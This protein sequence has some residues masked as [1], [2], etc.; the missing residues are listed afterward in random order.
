IVL[1]PIVGLLMGDLQTG[2]IVGGTLE[3]IFMGAVEIGGGVTANYTIGTIIGTAFA[4]TTG[5]DAQSALTIAVPAALI[6]S[7][8]EVLAKTGSTFIVNAVEESIRK[9]KIG[10]ITIAVH[11]GNLLHFLSNFIPIFL[12]LFFGIQAVENLLSSTPDWLQNG[13]GVAGNLLPALGF[14]LLLMTLVT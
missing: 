9:N 13:I 2:L 4:I 5:Q 6:G 1:A 7:F 10:G 12:A 11:S 3:L 14:A 8:F